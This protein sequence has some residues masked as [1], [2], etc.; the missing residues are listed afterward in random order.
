VVKSRAK[1]GW[2][3]PVV[4]HWGISGGRFAELTGDLSAG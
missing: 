3:A 1:I 2:D 4:S